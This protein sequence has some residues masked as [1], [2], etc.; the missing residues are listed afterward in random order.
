MHVLIIFKS[1]CSNLK[2]LEEEAFL[3]AKQKIN[4]YEYLI[5]Y[6]YLINEKEGLFDRAR[7]CFN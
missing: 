1:L 3:L 4:F 6:W 7:L 2:L 5:D